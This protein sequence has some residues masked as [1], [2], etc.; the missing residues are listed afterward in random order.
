MYNRSEKKKNNKKKNKLVSCKGVHFIKK[1]N[2]TPDLY[3][4][5]MHK[6]PLIYPLNFVV[7]SHSTIVWLGGKHVPEGY[8]HCRV[9]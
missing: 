1:E 3:I 9:T 8:I 2:E 4:N 7:M 6:K 5:F